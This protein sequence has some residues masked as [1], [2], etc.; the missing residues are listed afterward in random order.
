MRLLTGILAGLPFEATLIGDE[1]LSKRPM[2]R[3]AKPLREMGA[4]VRLSRGNYPPVTVKGSDRLKPI[5]WVNS[6]ASAQVKSCVL[7]AGLGVEG[8]TRYEE[9]VLSRDHTERMLR[10]A[11]AVIK[12]VGRTLVLKG[13]A[14]LSSRTWEVPGDP[15]SAAF[16]IAAG[17]LVKEARIELTDVGLN[18]TRTGFLA[19][20]KKM[21][22]SISIE[23]KKG[24]GE[25]VGTI[26]VAS[27]EKLTPIDLDKKGIPSLID[28]IPILAVVA[29][30]ARGV[31]FLRGLSELR[32]KETDRVSAMAEN[33]SKLG[34]KVQELKDGLAI[35]GPALFKGG[36]VKSYGDHRIAMAMAIAGLTAQKPVTIEGGDCVS[37]SYPRFWTDLA[38]LTPQ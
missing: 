20:L 18:P 27:H 24:D 36:T 9:P 22:V 19:A 30:R 5:R 8:E 11:G 28:E 32:V 33:L 6:V 35:E 13:P 2:D 29:C 21:G 26:V 12:P 4:D 34:V 31:S 7:F 38:A 14:R 17:L 16:F 23:T 3:I 37:I 1:S 10:A 25:P 15:S